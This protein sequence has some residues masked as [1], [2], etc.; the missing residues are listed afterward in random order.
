MIANAYPGLYNGLTTTCTYPDVMS[1]ATQ[2]ADYHILL[3]YFLTDVASN[4][5]NTTARDGTDFT[6][7]QQNAI[8]G[9]QNGQL[10][11]SLA[12]SALFSEAVDPASGC[13]GVPS[14]IANDPSTR[15]DQDTNPTGVRC[16]V[17]SFMQ[18]IVGARE[19][20]PAEDSTRDHWSEL[21]ATNG[22]G[23][24]GFPL[25]NEGVQY[26]LI[27]LQ[28]GTITPAQFVALNANIG[29]LD[30]S[31]NLIPTR[32]KVD[33]PALPNAYRSGIL[34]TI[35]NMDTVPIIN[36]TGPGPGAAHDSVHGYWVRWR[37]DREFG[38][39]DNFAHWGGNTALI[40][41]P[42]FMNQSLLAMADWLDAIEADTSDTPLAAKIIANRPASAADRCEEVQGQMCTEQQ[43]LVY[44]TPRTEA[45][46]AGNLDTAG[47]E[48]E[49]KDLG[50]QIQCVLRPFS[51]D[52]DYGL[53]NQPFPVGFSDEQW[54]QLEA[55]FDIDP[56]DEVTTPM[57]CDWTQ[58]PLGWQRT[59]TWLDYQDALGQMVTGGEQMAPAP[60][61]PGWGSDS[62]DSTWEPTWQQP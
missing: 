34:N 11:A 59:I 27:P 55:A 28:E 40:G 16:D 3:R 33:Y 24:A 46:A 37:L 9:H 57:V 6:A 61:P 39:H 38:H 14:T 43:M 1:T 47:T 45:G 5:L 2:F 31:L 56:S 42:K 30:P 58:R 7:A 15:F 10:N 12:D 51:R 13:G 26:G 49:G 62:F 52:D 21:E 48:A 25:G 54:E 41:N 36:M 53:G 4:P 22:Y 19:R 20:F 29:S 23:F 50:D 32:L 18:N 8:Y 17:L 44:G 60:Y 35:V